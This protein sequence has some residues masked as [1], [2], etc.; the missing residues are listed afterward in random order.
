MWNKQVDP[1]K[2]A[3]ICMLEEFP[4]MNMNTWFGLRYDFIFSP[5]VEDGIQNSLY[6]ANST[7]YPHTGALSPCELLC[8]PCLHPSSH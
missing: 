7:S 1:T 4:L 6:E 5:C 3:S 8:F 2:G